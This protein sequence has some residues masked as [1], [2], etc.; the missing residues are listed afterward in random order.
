MAS[1]ITSNLS[2][3][4]TKQQVL[5]S[6]A[7]IKCLAWK[8]TS[9][10]LHSKA[11]KDSHTLA[12]WTC[13][14]SVSIVNLLY[15]I[16]RF[17]AFLCIW[18]PFLHLYNYVLQSCFFWQTN[19][20]MG[21]RKTKSSVCSTV[22]SCKLTGRCQPETFRCVF[23]HANLD[24]TEKYFSFTQWLLL[25]KAQCLLYDMLKNITRYCL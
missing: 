20:Q 22:F 1:F 9:L 5:I 6:V 17:V 8:H 4:S 14:V 15:Y 12:F 3:L 21:R 11:V 24:K 7:L 25:I 2:W 19:T 18:A 13:F 23:S 10:L 16:L